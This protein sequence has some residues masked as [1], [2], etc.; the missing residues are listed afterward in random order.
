MRKAI[1][2]EELV[3]AGPRAPKKAICP[4]CGGKVQKRHRTRMDGQVTY[5][6]R[7]ARGEGKRCPERYRP[8]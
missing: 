1:V 7:H 6:Y 2:N 5:F 4:A 8:G 3:V